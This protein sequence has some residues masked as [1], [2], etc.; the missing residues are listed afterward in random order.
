MYQAHV[1]DPLADVAWCVRVVLPYPSVVSNA[2]DADAPAVGAPPDDGVLD[3]LGLLAYAHLTAFFRLSED[4]ALAISLSDK[5]ALAEMAVAELE[6]V[7]KELGFRGVEINTNVA[8]EDL[9]SQRPSLSGSSYLFSRSGSP[10][11]SG[12]ITTALTT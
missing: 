3:L 11:R 12:W 10:T 6:W 5:A 1:T 7:V 2:G 4:A 9:S 8:G